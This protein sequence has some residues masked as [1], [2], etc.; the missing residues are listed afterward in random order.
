MPESNAG[1]FRR[2]DQEEPMVGHK[3]IRQSL[4]AVSWRPARIAVL[5]AAAASCGGSPEASSNESKPDSVQEA[6]GFC[7]CV[8]SYFCGG[9]GYEVDYAPP[10]CGLPIEPD[11]H[12]ACDSNCFRPLP[13]LEEPWVTWVPST[14]VKTGWQCS[15]S[16]P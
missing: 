6:I 5:V 12:A 9:N 15:G 4:R 11:A 7:R 13:L 10:G 1:V 2:G 3:K 16:P 14:C 8:N